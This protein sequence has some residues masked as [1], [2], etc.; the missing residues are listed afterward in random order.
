MTTSVFHLHLEPLRNLPWTPI[1]SETNEKSNELQPPFKKSRLAEGEIV[2]W[3]PRL[4]VSLFLEECGSALTAH[5]QTRFLVK[6]IQVKLCPRNPNQ[7]LLICRH[8]Q[9]V[10]WCWIHPRGQQSRLLW[11]PA[12]KNVDSIWEWTGEAK[13]HLE[14]MLILQSEVREEALAA[15]LLAP[16]AD[17]CPIELSSVNIE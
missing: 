4:P 2:S 11:L 1:Q 7:L 12:H 16:D 17:S 3:I 14:I 6:D 10:A 15:G 13:G 5:L 8:D 9:Q